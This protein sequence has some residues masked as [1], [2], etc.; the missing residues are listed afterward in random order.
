MAARPYESARK[1]F[2]ALQLQ[3]R[4]A[5]WKIGEICCKFLSSP[6][7]IKANQTKQKKWNK[8]KHTSELVI[9]LRSSLEVVPKILGKIEEGKKFQ[10]R[11]GW[12]F[13]YLCLIQIKDF[14]SRQMPWQQIMGYCGQKKGTNA[15]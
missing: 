8:S 12:G 11:L 9:S 7:L 2:G 1:A 4:F 5:Y 6:S 14:I 10:D 15:E 3:D 13:N